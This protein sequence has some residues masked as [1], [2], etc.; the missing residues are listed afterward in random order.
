[1]IDYTE[2][3][4]N[5]RGRSIMARSL[6]LLGLIQLD[7]AR[8]DPKSIVIPAKAGIPLVTSTS[9]KRRSGP[10]AFAGVTGKVSALTC[11]DS[12]S[13]GWRDVDRSASL[14][15]R[16][17]SP[18]FPVNQFFFLMPPQNP[19]YSPAATAIQYVAPAET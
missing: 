14:P 15:F 5:G 2:A 6:I 12:A 18:R 11:Q 7:T 3:P 13:H 10:P 1:V 8:F 19:G 4:S 9:R 17:T 16:T